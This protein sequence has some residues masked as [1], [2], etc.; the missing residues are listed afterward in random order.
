MTTFD[1]PLISGPVAVRE[2]G[3]GPDAHQGVKRMPITKVR[4]CTR[5]GTAYLCKPVP[6]KTHYIFHGELSKGP[7]TKEASSRLKVTPK[8]PNVI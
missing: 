3:R 8:L 5:R 4:R 7:Q 6:G 2:P 1:L